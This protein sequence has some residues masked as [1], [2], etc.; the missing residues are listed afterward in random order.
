MM[1]YGGWRMVGAGPK[2]QSLHRSIFRAAAGR[3]CRVRDPAFREAIRGIRS[4]G[5]HCPVHFVLPFG[6]RGS[7]CSKQ[8][9]IA[10][11]AA[12]A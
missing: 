1:E 2:G 8:W 9:S 12:P 10:F 11:I 6:K 7:S 5:C 4:C 3:A